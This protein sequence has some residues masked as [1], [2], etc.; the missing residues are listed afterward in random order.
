MLW[1]LQTAY[2]NT[3]FLLPAHL[4]LAKFPLTQRITQVVLSEPAALLRLS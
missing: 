4:N 2:L 1:M 3:T